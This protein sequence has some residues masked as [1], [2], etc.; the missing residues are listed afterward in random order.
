MKPLFTFLG[1][2]GQEKNIYNFFL[3]HSSKI[4]SGKCVLN[5]IS[6]KDFVDS[7]L[8]SKMFFFKYSVFYNLK[9]Q[10]LAQHLNVTQ[11]RSFLLWSL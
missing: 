5:Q 11:F 2:S 7:L 10:W 6:F 1:Q 9:K 8:C 4:D 3:Y